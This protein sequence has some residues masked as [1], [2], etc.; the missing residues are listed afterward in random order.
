MAIYTL[1]LRVQKRV[2]R[3]FNFIITNA[4]KSSPEQKPL[5]PKAKKANKEEKLQYDILNRLNYFELPESDIPLKFALC[6]NGVIQVKLSC[7]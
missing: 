3:R 7:N 1:I 2:T 5:D 6:I 4:E